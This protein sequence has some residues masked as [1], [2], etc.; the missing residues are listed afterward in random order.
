MASPGF[1]GWGG[2]NDGEHGARAYRGYG[3]ETPSGVQGQSSWSGPVQGALPPEA[4]S[5]GMFL[6]GSFR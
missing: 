3:G 4:E 6:K 1:G 5:S 2:D